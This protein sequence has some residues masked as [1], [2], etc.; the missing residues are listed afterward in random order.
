MAAFM[1]AF[2]MSWSLVAGKPRS[3]GRIE[4]FRNALQSG[5]SHQDLSGPVE[6]GNGGM[7]SGK[8]ASRNST[9]GLSSP[10]VLLRRSRPQSTHRWMSTQRPFPRTVT[11]MGS[12]PPEQ[13]A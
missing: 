4:A 7:V 2:G 9:S 13:C 10:A 11:A 1:A 3:L 8:A 12:M 5:P 6:T